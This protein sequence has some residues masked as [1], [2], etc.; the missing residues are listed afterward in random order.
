MDTIDHTVAEPSGMDCC[1]KLYVGEGRDLID[2]N[3]PNSALNCTLNMSC[4]KNK[5]MCNMNGKQKNN[6]M[7]GD[8]NSNSISYCI[9]PGPGPQTEKQTV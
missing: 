9:G 5:Y 2:I 7:R 8:R 4:K 1:C 3:F 6:R